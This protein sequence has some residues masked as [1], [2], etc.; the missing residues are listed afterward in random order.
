M[1][2]PDVGLQFR[3]QKEKW[4]EQEQ[5]NINRDNL[6]YQDILYDGE[7]KI[8]ISNLLFCK[9]AFILLLS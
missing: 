1:I 5:I 9:E 8:K 7:L 2:G 6:H 4:H 3:L